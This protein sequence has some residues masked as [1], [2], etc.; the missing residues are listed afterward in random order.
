[1]AEIERHLQ[2]PS[3]APKTRPIDSNP[4]R[5]RIAALL[6][7]E[8]AG[9]LRNLNGVMHPSYR[10]GTIFEVPEHCFEPDEWTRALIRGLAN[11]SLHVEDQTV[12][13]V[14]VGTGAGSAFI[15]SER[16]PARVFGSDLDE[17]LPR[18]AQRNL[19][20]NVP[21]KADKFFPVGKGANLTRWL[22]NEQVID[23]AF[24]CLPQVV[25]PEGMKLTESDRRA[26]YY[27]PNEY[28]SKLHHLG[29]GLNDCM[30]RETHDKLR[31]RGSVVLT[32]SG[33]P[34]REEVL[35]QELFQANGYEP[36]LL[37]EEMIHQHGAT[38]LARLVEV[39][40]QNGFRFEFFGDADGKERIDAT[41][42]ERR[43]LMEQAIYHKIY[44]IE[45][46]K[47]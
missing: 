22:K 25:M 13:E 45:G 34:G 3:N 43:R 37:H 21:D 46:R 7:E 19:A 29:L 5:L 28:Q 18:V 15:L 17:R 16:N 23:V 42:A 38:S 4:R 33:R 12:L 6:Q 36:H 2:E 10:G 8:V 32:L 9:D 35:D 39:E 1:M 40:H 27:D 26:H 47:I 30:L 11:S 14:G 44:I 41:E 31:K 20:R 24:G